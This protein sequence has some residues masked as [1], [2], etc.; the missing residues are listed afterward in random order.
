MIVAL[1]IAPLRDHTGRVTHLIPSAVDIT[2][3]RKAEDEL[4]CSNRLLQTVTETA[5][6]AI[7][8]KDRAGRML[9]VIPT[10][11]D[12]IGK[13]ASELVGG[14]E[15]DWHGNVDEALAIMENDRRIVET[16]QPEVFEE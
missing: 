1:Q 7:Y 11:A 12:A 13:P 14:H 4:V 15:L 2:E 9:L 10:A 6:D 8:A 16:A 3:R 5:P